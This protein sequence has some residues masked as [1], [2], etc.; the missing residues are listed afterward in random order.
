MS[1]LK[2]D[3]SKYQSLVKMTK[4]SKM[5]TARSFY[6]RE[7]RIED[8][9]KKP[10]FNFHYDRMN[11]SA[12]IKDFYYLKGQEIEQPD[13]A[14]LIFN[15]K[16]K[17]R[18]QLKLKEDEVGFHIGM[19]YHILSAGLIPANAHAVYLPNMDG[20]ARAS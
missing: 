9:I 3:A 20:L 4:E 8:D 11:M 1:T 10:S 14:G 17:E 7:R 2:P 5:T 6:Y 18:Y 15:T 16:N 19:T 13:G 12:C